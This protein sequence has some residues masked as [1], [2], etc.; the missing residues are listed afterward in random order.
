[1]FLATV[2]AILI[3][4]AP[5]H[6]TIHII[7]ERSKVSWRV[8]SHS[9]IF[10]PYGDVTIAVE[11]LSILTY[12]KHI[13]PLSIEGSITCCDTSKPFLMVTWWLFLIFLDYF[14]VNIWLEWWTLLKT[15]SLSFLCWLLG[16]FLA[17][18][19]NMNMFIKVLLKVKKKVMNETDFYLII[20]L[21]IFLSWCKLNTKRNIIMNSD[22]FF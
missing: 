2:R 14:R 7:L 15:N 20:N 13:W 4:R 1:M 22:S 10:R 19:T 3:Q 16:D 8:S 12:A 6:C 18:W 5:S 11:G 21:I 9:R 17:P